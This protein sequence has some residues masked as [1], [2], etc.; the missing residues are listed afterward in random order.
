MNKE[1]ALAYCYEHKDQYII[2]YGNVSE[3]IRAFECLICILKD[4]TIGPE[5]LAYY[6]MEY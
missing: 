2:D 3:G 6:G 1:E 4:G 5:D